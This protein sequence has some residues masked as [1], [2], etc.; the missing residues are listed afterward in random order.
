MKLNALYIR[1]NNEPILITV[2]KSKKFFLYLLFSG[3]G[4]GITNM[5][6]Y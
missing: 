4:T 2:F 3:R 1:F 6:I 5:F